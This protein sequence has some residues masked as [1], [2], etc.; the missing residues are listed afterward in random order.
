M[1]CS[2]F[3]NG[4]W[5]SARSI[6]TLVFYAP[7]ILT[8]AYTGM[9]W[10]ELAGLTTKC[11]NPL[12]RAIDV[13]EQIVDVGGKLQKGEPKTKAARRRIEVPASLMTLLEDRLQDP[14]SIS[15]GLVFPTPSGTVMRPGNFR[16]RVWQPALTKAGLDWSLT[17]HDLRHTA[18]A[19]AISAGGN[20]LLIKRQMG[21]SSIGVTFG[22]YGHLLEGG[23]RR[24][25]DALDLILQQ[26]TA[27]F[28]RT[29]DPDPSSDAVDEPVADAL[30]RDVGSGASWNRT[31]DLILIRDAL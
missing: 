18:V 5:T 19:L 13:V 24:L 21:H 25:A 12:H 6:N 31:S 15:S 26:S 7:L 3:S 17:F 14:A 22:T 27:D 4:K 28:S 29:N 20:G 23:D 8:A 16:R 30:T 11:L 9:R 1:T 10:S 2:S